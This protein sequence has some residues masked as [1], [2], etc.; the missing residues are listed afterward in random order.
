MHEVAD[1]LVRHAA[2]AG[3]PT[4]AVDRQDVAWP[5]TEPHSSPTSAPNASALSGEA[6]SPAGGRLRIRLR[7]A[8]VD[9]D[10][11]LAL[12]TPASRRGCGCP[13]RMGDEFLGLR[14][15]VRDLGLVT[16][17]EEAGCPNIFEC[18]ADGTA[19]FMINGERCTRACGFCL[20]DTRHPVPPDPDEPERVAEAVE[21]LGLAHAVVTAVARDDLADGGAAG[22]AATIAA[23]RRHGARRRRSRCSSPTARATRRRWRRSSRR[24][25]T[26]STTTSR[27]WPACSAPFAPRPATPAASPCWPG[28]RTP[29]S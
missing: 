17:C 20:V 13:A 14:R 7:Q 11:G 24:V 10:A 18:W 4:G 27:P 16:V 23:I 19:T 29:G 8:G 15:T 21:R 6:A 2:R 28:P 3:L 25:P 22:F 1:L 12:P 5:F 26:C 9:P